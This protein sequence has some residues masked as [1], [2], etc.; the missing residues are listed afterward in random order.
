MNLNDTDFQLFAVPATFAQ[1]RAVLDAR[2]KELQREVHPD[3]FA[4]Q[5]AA[6]QRVAMQ[7]S[8]RINEAYQ[9][10]KDPIRRASYLCELNGAP[11]NAENNTAMPGAFLMQQMEWREALDDACDIAAVEVLQADVESTRARALSSLDWLI[12]EKGDYPGAVQQVR[13]LMF[14]ERFGEDV[15]KKF[16]QLGQ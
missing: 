10:L 16:D 9:R 15:E 12:D 14:I 8:V 2:W 1:D 5:G 13:A 3:R 7:W 6:A 4:A 11:L